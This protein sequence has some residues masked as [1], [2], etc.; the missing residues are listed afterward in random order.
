MSRRKTHEEYVNELATINPNIDVLEQYI[1]ANTKI[2]HRCKIDGHI[3]CPAP[4]SVLGGQGCPECKRR[5]LAALHQKTHEQYVAA[6][7]ITHPN[8][9]VLERY[10]DAKTKILHR[11]K[12]DGYEWKVA[13]QNITQ[14]CGCPVCAGKAVLA[15]YNDLATTHPYLVSEW[16]YEENGL[17]LPT[18]VSHGTERIVGWICKSGH[19]YKCSVYDKAKGLQCKVCNLENRKS[20]QE[21]RVYYYIR[22]YF[23]D[24]ISGHKN[25][26]DG[27]PE[28]DIYIP[29]L[30]FAIE[31]DGAYY[32]K[33]PEKDKQKDDIC[34]TLNIH[35]V[36]IRE[37]GCPQ[38]DSNCDFIYLENNDGRDLVNAI[39]SVLQTLNIK[40]PDID[41]MRDSGKI[42][43]LVYH[44]KLENSLQERYPEVAQDWHPTKNG[45]L[46]PEHVS[47]KSCK[48]VWWLC[49]TCKYEW[50]STITN[51][52]SKNQKCPNC[53]GGIAKIVYCIELNKIFTCI[54]DASRETGAQKNSI[55]KSCYDENKFAGQHP[56]TNEPLHWRCVYDK[57]NKDG[58]VVL[59]AISLG[60]VS[61]EQV[62]KIRGI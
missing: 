42:N 41:F 10:I 26:A 36:R 32:H 30:K 47:Q 9:E 44:K 39:R 35:L 38:Y 61:S 24:A 62:R 13:P 5:T 20:W 34:N 45:N 3:W 2:A 16:D 22:K 11:C 27:L 31:Y 46:T 25:N 43:N 53:N 60:Y 23:P 12:I 4:G 28:L 29:S 52:T 21:L 57:I 33:N 18:M 55:S 48:N 59:G 40:E 19:K 6:I 51:R 54:K 1:N 37:Y 58:S 56:E 17:L 15:G 50:L 8:I 7:N 49:H 14:G